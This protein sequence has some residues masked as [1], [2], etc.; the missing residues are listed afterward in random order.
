MERRWKNKDNENVQKIQWHPAFVAATKIEFEDERE[1]LKFESEYQLSKKPMQIDLLILKKVENVSIYK[2]IGK[3]F[4]GNNVLEYKSP[5]DYMGVD[6][7]YKVYGYACFYKADSEKV[8]SI[9]IDD[10]TISLVSKKYPRKVIEHLTK[11]RGYKIRKEEEG[12]YYVEGD[13]FPI[14]ILVTSRLSKEK[15]L[16]LSSLTDQL[17]NDKIHDLMS[18]YLHNR[19]NPLYRSV[20]KTVTDANQKKFKEVLGVR[21][22]DEILF[23]IAIQKASPE[24]KARVFAQ[25]SE[26]DREKIR[27]KAE[28]EVKEELREKI[29]EARK[30]A[31]E[32]AR[33]KAEEEVKEELREK[34]EEARKKAEEEARK[35]AEEE[36]KE[37]LR[38]EV[39]VTSEKINILFRKLNQEGRMSEWIRSTEDLEYQ[40]ELIREMENKRI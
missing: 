10:I 30:K 4:R 35:K 40:R 27:K 24:M 21:S 17:E 31:E 22:A 36:V 38:K 26:E 6:D 12:I 16:W 23:D 15:N 5:T 28:E 32:E 33:K 11:E 20:M 19:K 2:N 34:I 7:F 1:K 9:A 25:V 3:I 39:E 37:E 29:E 13:I 18:V 14:Q 8:N